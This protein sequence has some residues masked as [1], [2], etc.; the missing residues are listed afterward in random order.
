MAPQATY[1]R[2]YHDDDFAAQDWSLIV[3]SEEP[4]R[5]VET[6]QTSTRTDLENEFLHSVL[7]RWEY[8]GVAT[9]TQTMGE[10]GKPRVEETTQYFQVT[11]KRGSHSRPHLMPTFDS[12]EDIVLT[13]TV[14][15][16]IQPLPRVRGPL[17][18]ALS[19][20]SS[21]VCGCFRTPTHIG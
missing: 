4:Q 20:R 1:Q 13:A 19:Q 3:D 9:R 5:P 14:A 15:I 2:I 12:A 6:E 8:Y 7:V 17:L 21:R 18:T 10:D 16:D 11:G